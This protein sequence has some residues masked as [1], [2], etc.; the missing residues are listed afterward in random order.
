MYIQF[1]RVF[2]A[3]YATLSGNAVDAEMLV[4]KPVTCAYLLT[5]WIKAT[6]GRIES[7]DTTLID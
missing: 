3:V 1:P 5:T 2:E 6:D 7:L 4:Q